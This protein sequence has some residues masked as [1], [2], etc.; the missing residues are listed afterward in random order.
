MSERTIRER[1]GFTRFFVKATAEG[2]TVRAADY[3]R[4]L[5][6]W[7]AGR[8]FFDGIDCYGDPLTVKLGDVIAIVLATPAGIERYDEDQQ[9]EKQRELLHGEG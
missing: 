3:E 8:A 9:I 2:F 4:M 7:K 5:S 1:E 6:E